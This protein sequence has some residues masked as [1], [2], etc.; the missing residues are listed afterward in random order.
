VSRVTIKITHPQRPDG[1]LGFTP[2]YVLKNGTSQYIYGIEDHVFPTID[3][4]R[5]KIK[6]IF[7][8]KVYDLREKPDGTFSRKL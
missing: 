8:G 2:R 7:T 6:S 3:A 1:T 4:A 5:E